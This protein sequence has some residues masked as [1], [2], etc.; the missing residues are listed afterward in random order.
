[1]A[2]APG[3]GE[4][5]QRADGRGRCLPQDASYDPSKTVASV[6]PSREETKNKEL[7]PPAPRQRLRRPAGPQR[8][9][10]AGRSKV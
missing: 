6:L 2:R 8:C 7:L 5:G 3:V 9:F 1:M 10:R 4:P